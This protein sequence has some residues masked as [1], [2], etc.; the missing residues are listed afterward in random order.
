MSAS[1][2]RCLLHGAAFIGAGDSAG[3]A[4]PL[5]M[6]L[7]WK[8]YLLLNSAFFIGLE[9]SQYGYD[10]LQAELIAIAKERAKKTKKE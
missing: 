8:K 2:L 7:Q 1:M 9:F 3:I 6:I 5:K 10:K 4:Q